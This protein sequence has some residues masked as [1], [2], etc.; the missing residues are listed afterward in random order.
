MIS[1]IADVD[2]AIPGGTVNFTFFSFFCNGIEGTTVAFRGNGSSGQ[3]GVYALVGGYLVKISD[4]T[5]AIP[6]GT[7]NF[8]GFSTAYIDEGDFAFIVD[9]SSD[10]Q[11]IYL[12]SGGTL[13][14]IDDKTTPAPGIGGTYQWS[15]QLGFEGGHLSF[16]ANVT[17][18]T[19]PGNIIGG[20][21]PGEPFP[22]SSR[23][24]Q[25]SRESAHPSP[26]C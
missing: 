10:Q 14:R 4:T 1:R 18:G 17:G 8:T 11:G 24:P 6:N 2:T 9:G 25:P 23:P 21:T 13:T 15:S 19:N 22:P 16:W 3:A 5:T 12:S 7:G 20:N 26:A